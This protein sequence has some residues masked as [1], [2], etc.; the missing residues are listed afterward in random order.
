M[1]GGGGGGSS[2]RLT[3]LI[4]V[5]CMERDLPREDPGHTASLNSLILTVSSSFATSG[6]YHAL[7][8]ALC[9][10][11][12]QGQS[13]PSGPHERRGDIVLARL[14]WVA[15]K[16]TD[17]GYLDNDVNAYIQ[18]FLRG[19]TSCMEVRKSEDP[20]AADQSLWNTPPK[21]GCQ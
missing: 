3:E 2:Y 8:Q 10:N 18:V 19:R 20:L 15:R 6:V 5:S 21:Q 17:S 4:T 12:F 14:F 11:S 16:K 7:Y 13:L 1:G 9:Q